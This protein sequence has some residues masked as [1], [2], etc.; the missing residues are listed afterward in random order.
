MK[1][2]F[3]ER[4]LVAVLGA[5]AAAACSGLPS[6]ERL[7]RD[8]PAKRIEL[9]NARALVA[10]IAPG[11][12]HLRVASDWSRPALPDEPLTALR[13]SLRNAGISMG[14]ERTDRAFLFIVETT[15]II[16]RGWAKGYAWLQHP[17][18]AAALRDNLDKTVGLPRDRLSLTPLPG[19][20]HWYLYAEP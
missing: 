17:P 14:V 15:G 1:N 2:L 5:V 11:T 8:F 7:I 13:A 6:D 4:L 10:R 9:E 16:G 3:A 18:V 20:K 19:E 12:Y